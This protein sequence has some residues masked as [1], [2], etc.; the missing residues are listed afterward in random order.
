[1]HYP[2][3]AFHNFNPALDYKSVTIYF[4]VFGI[5]VDSVYDKLSKDPMMTKT[6]ELGNQEHF[7][8]ELKRKDM[9]FTYLVPTDLAWNAVKDD[10][11][12]AHKVKPFQFKRMLFLD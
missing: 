12:T 10:M 11:A 6:F 4:Q 8:D 1:M 5:P 3:T 7:N 9:E 2:K